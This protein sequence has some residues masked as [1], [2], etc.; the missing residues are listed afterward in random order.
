MYLQE[1]DLEPAQKTE[2]RPV[3]PGPAARVRPLVVSAPRQ[4]GD[5]FSGPFP[6]SVDE[7]LAIRLG[8][9]R[10]AAG[11]VRRHLLRSTRRLGV[12]LLADAVA[13][14]FIDL[15]IQSGRHGGFV[16]LDLLFPP[17]A[18]ASPQNL[19]ALLIGLY[20][21][22]NYSAGDFRRSPQRLFV[23][24]LVA[25]LLQIWAVVWSVGLVAN[26]LQLIYAA[27]VVFTGLLAER[28]F[29]DRIVAWASLPEKHAAR[30]LF[31]GP[32]EDCR[33]AAAYPALSSSA[34]FAPLGF[35]DMRSPPAPD[36]LGGLADLPRVLHDSRV[37]TVVACGYIPDR[38]LQE[39][40]NISLGAGCHL[41]TV[42]RSIEVAGVQPSLIWTRGS[43]L[44]QLTAPS[45]HGQQ[46]VLKRALDI[47]G[48]ALGLVLAAP[49]M[50]V[51]AVAIK[52]DS[53]GPVF[54][55]QERIGVGGRRFRVWKFRTMTHG[56]P[57]TVHREYMTE[58][59]TGD[60]SSTRQLG[61]NGKPIFKMASDPRVTRV[62][63]F[64]RRSSLDELPQFLN[65]LMG[66]MSLVGPRPPIPYEFEMYD[67]WQFDRLQVRPGITGLW[68]VSGR[69]LLSYRQMCELDVDYVRR[70][71]ILLDLRILLK[72]LPVVLF[73]AGK[74]V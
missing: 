31:V 12:L 20:V 57:D 52:L 39:L 30:T 33:E 13:V 64:L 51:L 3:E 59:L 65:V 69:S 47:A 40:V 9:Q 24:V 54:F 37:E 10:R 42:P 25:L 72:T 27:L 19:L 68:Q 34:D 56:A 48:S 38:E 5:R 73:N 50:A 22:G 7:V 63:R 16:I 53:P 11:N 36:S 43:P 41:L 74:P 23:G 35:L 67:H 61:P 8:L 58:M 14:L 28:L 32:A 55:R 18:L 17:G 70:W 15:L 60:E 66:E 6:R 46:L 26:V 62:G 44:M 4:G 29:V 1:T 71:S 45:L 49:I 2:R 21:A